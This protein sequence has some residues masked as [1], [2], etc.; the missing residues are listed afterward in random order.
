V[1][2]A[3]ARD[4]LRLIHH[5]TLDLASMPEKLRFTEPRRVATRDRG[6]GPVR[7]GIRPGMG[8]EIERGVLVDQ[9][10]PNTSADNGGMKAGDIIIGWNDS[11][12]DDIRALFEALQQHQPDDVVAITVLRDGEEVVL[13]VTLQAGE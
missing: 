8:Q 3:G 1:T 2:P 13:E 6:Y 7:L 4:V 5:I 10:S 12:I 11:P 9:V